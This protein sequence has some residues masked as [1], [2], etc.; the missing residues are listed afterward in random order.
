MS[1]KTRIKN[2]RLKVEFDFVDIILETI[3]IFFIVISVCIMLYHWDDLPSL[4]PQHFNIK[5]EPD[6][7]TDKNNLWLLP[8]IGV[9]IYLGLTVI[10]RFPYLLNYP[11]EIN[12]GNAF[13]QYVLATKLIRVLKVMTIATFTYITFQIVQISLSAEHQQ[14]PGNSL[15]LALVTF[16]LPIVAYLYLAVKNR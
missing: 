4:V 15:V 16:I 14:F 8:A 3:G 1:L 6:S 9:L 5:G 13:R 10:E 12:D 2:P 11:F 7:Y